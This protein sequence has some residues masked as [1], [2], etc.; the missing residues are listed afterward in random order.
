MIQRKLFPK[1]SHMMRRKNCLPCLDEILQKLKESS[2]QYSNIFNISV[3]RLLLLFFFHF[4]IN[5]YQQQNIECLD[6]MFKVTV[7]LYACH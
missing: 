7:Q 2:S 1:I 4:S 5:L 3:L 6:K